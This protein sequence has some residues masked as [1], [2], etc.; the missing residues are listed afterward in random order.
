MA[1]RDGFRVTVKS[2]ATAANEAAR[3][4]VA[5]RGETLRFASRDAAGT[6]AARLSESGAT[7]VAIQRAAPQDPDDVDAY[8]V[9]SPDRRTHDPIESADGRLTFETTAAQYGALG[10]AL[11][12]RHRVNPPALTAYAR[13]DLEDD[14]SG[15]AER[16]L[17]VEVDPD[18]EPVVY[19]GRDPETRLAWV[20]D[21]VA[22]VRAGIGGD[23]LRAYHCEVKTG[24]ASFQRDQAAVMAYE[25]REATV[26]KVRL[27]V[28]DLPDAYT[29]R[30]DEVAPEEPPAGLRR[31]PS[32]DARLD[33]F[34]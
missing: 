28:T 22:R 8:L 20:P 11:V 16:A 23:V 30:I 7:P 14:L 31:G 13:A 15:D 34:A 32:P 1:E 33:D 10:E 9:A 29:V 25:A 3:A 19:A 4:L 6:E 5:E 18:P 26:L 24:D 12:C 21:C 17:R 2:S 27:A